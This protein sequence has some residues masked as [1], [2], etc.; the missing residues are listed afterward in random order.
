MHWLP[1]EERTRNCHV[2]SEWDVSCKFLLVKTAHMMLS[3]SLFDASC[4]GAMFSS[5]SRADID[6]VGFKL[7]NSWF[8]CNLLVYRTFGK[9]FVI[10]LVRRSGYIEK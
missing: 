7:S 4:I 6:I 1:W 2:W 10:N 9:C 5:I 8:R 3:V